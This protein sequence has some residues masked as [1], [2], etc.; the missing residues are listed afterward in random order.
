MILSRQEFDEIYRVYY[1][2][3]TAFARQYISVEE[4]I[5][6]IVQDIFVEL[7]DKN[8][9]ICINYSIT[10]FLFTLVKNRCLNFLR[11]QLVEEEYGNYIREEVKFK[12]YSLESLD[13]NYPDEDHLQRRIDKAI[14]Q[15][16]ERCREIFVMS[17]LQGKK[18][19]EIASEL[20]IS[21]NTVEN[22]IVT[23]LRK[24]RYELKDCLILLLFVC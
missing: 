2:K 24:L 20:G 11:H 19:K 13:Y 12:L 10:T 5:E 14:Q 8:E 22:Q 1:I 16:P 7:W 18:Y 3:M 9:E 23:A 17:K 4:D 21:V 15:L 6:N